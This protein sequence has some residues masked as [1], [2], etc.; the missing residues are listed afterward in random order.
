ML[1][2][3]CFKMSLEPGWDNGAV[4]PMQYQKLSRNWEGEVLWTELFGGEELKKGN[5][6]QRAYTRAT[7]SR[8]SG[9]LALGHIPNYYNSFPLIFSY[10]WELF[11]SDLTRLVISREGAPVLVHIL[12]AWFSLE[13]RAWED[14]LA[15]YRQTSEMP[16]V[17]FQSSAKKAN[18]TIRRLT[19]MFW[20]SSALKSFA[21]T[22]LY[23][24][25]C[26]I[27]RYASLNLK[28]FVA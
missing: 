4:N 20:L 21:Y 9:S 17:P 22:I 8:N 3:R 14:W 25:K 26:A 6:V 13:F 7:L 18:F 5:E 24:V 23:L 2:V 15:G 12:L 27:A 16:G 28:Q 1:S 11:H 19:W 10:T